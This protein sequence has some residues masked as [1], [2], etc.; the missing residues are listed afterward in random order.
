MGKGA[1]LGR[2]RHRRLTPTHERMRDGSATRLHAL[3]D[4]LGRLAAFTMTCGLMIHRSQQRWSATCPTLPLAAGH[5]FD[6]DAL[7]RLLLA[8]GAMPFIPN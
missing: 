2:W 5:A 3:V 1:L 4:G 6:N 7:G 8:R